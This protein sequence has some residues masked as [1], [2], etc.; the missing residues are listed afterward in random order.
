M[1]PQNKS[2]ILFLVQLPPPVHGVSM[3]NKITVDSSKI[4]DA[5]DTKT[6]PLNYTSE[7]KGIGKFSW[8]K[9]AVFFKI[10]K[11]LISTLRQ[12][13]PDV[14]YFTLTP[15]GL[16]FYRDLCIVY[17]IKLTRSKIVFHLHGKGIYN[18]SKRSSMLRFIY[19]QVFKNTY[20][21]H[22]AETLKQDV[23]LVNHQ[24][25]ASYAIPN[26]ISEE[27]Q[28]PRTVSKNKGTKRLL[29]LSNI[30]E[31]KGVLMFLESCRYL[32]DQG[33]DFKAKIVGRESTLISEDDIRQKIIDIGLNKEVQYL[34]P[35]YNTEKEHIFQNS[36]IFVF[37]TYN[38]CFPLVI[39]EA[40]KYGLAVL[41]TTE[42][43]IPDIID[44]EKNGL[45]V[46]RKDQKALNEKLKM[47]ML[48]DQLIAEFSKKAREK[49]M[50]EYTT[51]R[52]EAN[53][54]SVLTQIAHESN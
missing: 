52:Y 34:G 45:I 42:G 43:A 33:F 12:F 1:K 15:T 9:I 48:D 13:K 40:F 30:A 46:P 7:I 32:K 36:D 51:D 11:T 2:K 10:Y 5:F 35:K 49:F 8:K 21:I 25:K 29:F 50:L 54:L 24:A 23:M 31:N 47:M 4:Q 44:N 3:M 14:I 38:D 27:I 16:S 18:K 19:K 6:I 26:G 22:L 28:N 53:V 17:L 37:P 39:L 20:I 41:S